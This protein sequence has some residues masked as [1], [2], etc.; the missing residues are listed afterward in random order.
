MENKQDSHIKKS[1]TKQASICINFNT[2][3]KLHQKVLL[4][5]HGHCGDPINIFY[6]QSQK[7]NVFKHT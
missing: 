5:E 2:P 4:T 3:L 1:K 7:Q 6:S